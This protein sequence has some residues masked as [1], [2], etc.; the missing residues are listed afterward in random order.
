MTRRPAIIGGLVAALALAVVLAIILSGGDD[1]DNE[2]ELTR[3]ARAMALATAPGGD[4]YA[5]VEQI[6]NGMRRSAVGRVNDGG[7]IDAKP[8]DLPIDDVTAIASE[9]DD[10]LLVAGTRM[11]DGTRQLAIGRLGT[12]GR[13]DRSFGANGVLMIKAGDGDAIARG[14]ATSPGGAS[15]AVLAD[16]TRNDHHAMAVAHVDLG[17]GHTTVDL[18]DETAAGGIAPSR[19]NS[20]LAAG[21]DTRT[22]GAVVARL[23]ATPSAGVSRLRT[24]LRSASWRAVAP[25]PD[26]GAVIVGSGRDRDLRSLAA[27]VRVTAELTEA[28]RGTVPVGDG[29]GYGEAV[30]VDPDERIRIA[31]NG[32]QDDAP[33]AYL[34]TLPGDGKPPRKAAGRAAG[35][36]PEGGILATRWDGERQSVAFH[37]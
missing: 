18:V 11:V 2:S 22:G 23:D 17:T 7:E 31:A 1:G 26:G 6:D 24:N 19:N 5:L 35:L 29:D 4:A 16:A 10:A 34:I 32:S 36:T 37:P 8:I 20:F 25:T 12:D 33:A 21:T 3:P 27:F 28:G 13:P 14:I 15:A 30:Q 9:R